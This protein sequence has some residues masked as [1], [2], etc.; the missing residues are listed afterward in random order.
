[1]GLVPTSIIVGIKT[2]KMLDPRLPRLSFAGLNRAVM[3]SFPGLCLLV[4]PPSGCFRDSWERRSGPVYWTSAELQLRVV[5][6]PTASRMLLLYADR[7]HGYFLLATVEITSGSLVKDLPALESIRPL[8]PFPDPRKGIEAE[9]LETRISVARLTHSMLSGSYIVQAPTTLLADT[10]SRCSAC[11][12][13]RRHGSRYHG[14][15]EDLTCP[16]SADIDPF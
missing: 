13:H 7:S 11:N 2:S 8:K 15:P 3:S 4:S 12:K 16:P 1:M 14:P 6:D 9:G 5:A 10:I